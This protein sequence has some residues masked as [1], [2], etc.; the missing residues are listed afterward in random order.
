[1]AF[2]VCANLGISSN[3]YTFGYVAMWSDD[4]DEAIAAIKSSGTRIQRAAETILAKLG[5]AD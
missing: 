4:G 5:E 2:I 3:D 1:V